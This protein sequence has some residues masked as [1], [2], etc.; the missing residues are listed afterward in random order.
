[1]DELKQQIISIIKETLPTITDSDNIDEDNNLQ[2]FGLD[3][4]RCVELVIALEDYFKIEIP[5]EKLSINNFSNLQDIL[6]LV[7]N[8]LSKNKPF[9]K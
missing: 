3:S 6:L 4:L 9:I 5:E 2:N 7:E 8:C 1:M